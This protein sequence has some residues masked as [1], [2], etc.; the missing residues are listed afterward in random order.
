MPTARF[1]ICE[2]T[3]RWAAAW[4]RVLPLDEVKVSELRGFDPCQR[5]LAELPYSVV[6]VEV[7][8]RNLSAALTQ[9]VAWR[10]RFP[11]AVFL[12]PA[13]RGLERANLLLREAGAAHVVFSPRNLGPTAALIRRHLAAAPAPAAPLEETIWQTLPWGR[14]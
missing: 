6:A 5:A 12:I 10:R 8:R 4:R 7:T 13:D 1:L 3:G 2:K 9:L 11:H 14:K